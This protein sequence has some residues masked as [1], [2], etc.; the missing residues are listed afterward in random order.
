[1]PKAALQDDERPTDMPSLKQ[2]SSLCQDFYL[3]N[4]DKQAIRRLQKISNLRGELRRLKSRYRQAEKQGLAELRDD[5]RKEIQCLRRAENLSRKR[6]ERRR[7]RAQFTSNPFQFVKRLLGEKK[8]GELQCTKEEANKYIKDMYSDSDRHKALGECDKLLTPD[9]PEHDFDCAEPRLQEV[10]D[11]VRKARASSAP[12]PNGVPYRVY[13]N[14]PKIL[15]RLWKLIKV[16]WRKGELCREWLK[17]EGCFIPKEEDSSTLGQFRTISLLNVEGKIIFAVLSI[18]MTSYLLLNKY[19]DTAVQKGGV[20]GVSGCIEHTSVITQIIKEA[21]EN[22]G[23]IAMLRHYFD[24]FIMRFSTRAITTDWQRLEVGIVT[25]CTIS[26]VLFA[27]AMNLIVKSAEKPSRGPKMTSGCI[28]PPTRAFMDDMTITAKSYVEERWMLQDIGELIEW[29][30]M[31]FKP[32]KSRS[33]VLRKG[34]IQESAIYRIKDQ[35]IPTVKEQPVKCLGKWFRDSLN[36]QQSIKDKVVQMENWLKDVDKC[37]LPGKFKA[38]IYQHGILPRLLWPLLVYSVP[39]S[40]VEA[41]ERTINSFL[42]RWMGVPKSFTS[43]GLYCTGSKLQIPLRS[44]TEEYKVTKAR[45]VIMLRDSRDEKVREAG[46]QVNTGRK[47]R[48]DKAVEEAEARLRHSDIVGNVAHGRLGFGCVTRSQWSK[49]SAKDRRTQVQEEIRRMEEESRL[50][51]AVTL[52]KQGK[53]LNWEGVPQRKLTWNAIW[54][55]ESDRLSFLFKSVYDVLPSPTNLVTWGLAE[56]PD[57]KLCGRP[58]NLEHVLSSCRT[59]LSDGRYRW[60]HDR[61]LASIADHLD[62]ARKAQ[63]TTNKGPSFIFFVRAGEEG[64]KA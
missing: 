11:I 58:A 19:I 39:S 54:T 59:A 18:R 31:K 1:M 6:H 5:V 34:K 47:W 55:M 57:C 33:M 51:R 50:T 48:A 12:G 28:Q 8:T 45:K 4:K 14:C 30:R 49:A 26:V 25:G 24:G 22:K 37:G 10:K 41:M 21:R 56:K 60:R 44:L 3:E 15:L 40:T 38:W 7:K 61:V 16:V 64:A 63:K 29:A 36:D 46:V 43:L 9:D 20:P 53:W 62:Q 27:A 13:K 42:R 2:K 17:A 52:R 32:Q 35:L 23:D